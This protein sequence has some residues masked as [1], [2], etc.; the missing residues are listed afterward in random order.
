LDEERI[1]NSLP[2]LQ[3]PVDEDEIAAEE[4]QVLT[5]IIMKSKIPKM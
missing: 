4:S 5:K 3:D 1:E 2:W